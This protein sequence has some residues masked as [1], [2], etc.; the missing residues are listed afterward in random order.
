MELELENL[1]EYADAE[2][3]IWIERG[4]ILRGKIRSIPEPSSVRHGWVFR[5]TV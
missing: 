5:V 3:F 2:R 1:Q 4:E